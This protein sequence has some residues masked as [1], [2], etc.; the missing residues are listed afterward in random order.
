MARRALTPSP[1]ARSIAADTSALD[2]ADVEAAAAE[3]ER[4]TVEEA[5]AYAPEREKAR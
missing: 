3:C 4:M 5:V 2:P 1:A